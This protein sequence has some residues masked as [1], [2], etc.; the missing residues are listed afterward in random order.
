MSF[1]QLPIIVA[2]LSHKIDAL[3][4]LIKER[5]PEPAFT[6]EERALTV[7]E[8]ADFL[9]IAKQT[10]YQNIKKIPSRKKHGRHYFLKSELTACLETSKRQTA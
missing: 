10:V 9:G 6:E 5:T 2:E 7:K 8:A 3:Y 4:T 1:D